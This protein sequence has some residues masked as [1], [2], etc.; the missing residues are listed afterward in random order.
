MVEDGSF[1]ISTEGLAE[2]GK[3]ITREIMIIKEAL[4]DIEATRKTLEGWVSQNKDRFD[5]KVASVLPK[6]YEITEILESFGSV[7]INT[8]ERAIN[9]EAKIAAAIDQNV[10]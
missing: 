8:S 2:K 6:M 1:K 4:A 7:A 9:L 3:E 5:S 10:A